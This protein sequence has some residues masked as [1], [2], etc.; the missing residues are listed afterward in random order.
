MPFNRKL[1]QQEYNKKHRKQ[2]N[3]AGRKRYWKNPEQHRETAR[4]WSKEHR[5]ACR[6]T[7]HNRAK[8]GLT[9]M[10]EYLRT[11]PCID[12]GET[13]VRVL[14]FDHVRG[15]KIRSVSYLAHKDSP[16]LAAEI[17]KCDIRCANCHHRR[18]LRTDSLLAVLIRRP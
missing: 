8:R 16:R 6:T 9:K 14:H 15:K 3:A 2:L 4:N 18:H 7:E 17:A 12:C 1:W 11:H 10:V 13:D 5:D